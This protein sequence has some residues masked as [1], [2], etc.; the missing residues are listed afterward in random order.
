VEAIMVSFNIWD[1][2]RLGESLESRPAKGRAPIE[3]G[4]DVI[5]NISNKTLSR[6][7]LE[8]KALKITPSPSLFSNDYIEVIIPIISYGTRL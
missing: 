2:R 3:I 5:P 7:L 6:I 4:E 8:S 1:E